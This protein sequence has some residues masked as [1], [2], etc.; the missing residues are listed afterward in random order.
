MASPRAPLQ[1]QIALLLTLVLVPIGCSGLITR[2]DDGRLERHGKQVVR[3][4]LGVATLGITSRLQLRVEERDRLE[5][6]ERERLLHAARARRLW[7]H[8]ILRARTEERLSQTFG[9]PPRGCRASSPGHRICTWTTQ[10]VLVRS[11]SQPRP[12]SGRVELPLGDGSLEPLVIA[13]CELPEGGSERRPRSC[14]VAFW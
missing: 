2:G 8:R 10:A 1:R 6:A 5:R 4:A 11:V 9:G 14:D 13:T 3:T 12:P 7:L